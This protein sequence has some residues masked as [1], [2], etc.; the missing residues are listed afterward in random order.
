[1]T[2]TTTDVFAQA[3]YDVRTTMVNRV[4]NQGEPCEHCQI[5][6]RFVDATVYGLKV[7][8][9]YGNTASVVL[10][11]C[12][13]CVPVLVLDMDPTADVTVE[14]GNS[15]TDDRMHDQDCECVHPDAV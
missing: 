8:P 11:C 4:D 13:F 14:L 2:S 12:V 10:E 9:P 5:E 7:F 15:V 6:G 3:G 1:M